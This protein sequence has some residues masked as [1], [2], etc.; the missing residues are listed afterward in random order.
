MIRNCKRLLFPS[1]TD[2]PQFEMTAALGKDEETEAL[3]NG[4]DLQPG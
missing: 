4:N 2:P 3:E 1:L